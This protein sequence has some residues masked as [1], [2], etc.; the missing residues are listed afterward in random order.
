M[1]S[2]SSTRAGGGWRL[3]GCRKGRVVSRPL[4]ESLPLTAVTKRGPAGR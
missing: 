1:M 4:D 2:R 3:G